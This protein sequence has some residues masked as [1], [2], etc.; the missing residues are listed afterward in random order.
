MA[1]NFG[2]AMSGVVEKFKELMPFSTFRFI[3]R[4]MSLLPITYRVAIGEAAEAI[5]DQHW[6]LIAAEDRCV[7][8]NKSRDLKPSVINHLCV[9][10]QQC[11][12]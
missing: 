5:R 12:E 6:T 8:D 4:L 7:F 3:L 9:F 11:R 2:G 10:T 1:I